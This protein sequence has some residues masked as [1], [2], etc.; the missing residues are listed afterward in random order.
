MT[1][2]IDDL[3]HYADDLTS[4]VSPFAAQRAVRS[5]LTPDTRR[6]R[7]AVVVLV[8]TALFGVS[9]VALAATADPAI[10]G[11]A[12]YSV[13]RAYERVADLTGLGGPRVT[14]R[15]AETGALVEQGRLAEA[16]GLV[17]ETLGKVLESDDPQ[18][19]LDELTEAM[20]NVPDAVSDLVLNGLVAEARGISN[21]S[22]TGQQIAD[23]ARQ[24][25]QEL[26][27]RLA[28]ENSNRPDDA[29]PPEDLPGSTNSGNPP[30]RP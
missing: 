29:G 9:N 22:Y 5:A 12:L 30:N 3:R 27:R 10:P 21:G 14:E 23:V 17:Q 25:G 4:E 20:G 2:P 16:L 13:D 15:L 28:E 24:L 18:A 7:K 19:E 26:G 1:N 11:D 6:P 8:T